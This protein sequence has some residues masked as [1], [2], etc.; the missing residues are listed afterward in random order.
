[1]P[2]REDKNKFLRSEEAAVPVKGVVPVD[3]MQGDDDEDTKLLR[4]MAQVARRYLRTF[5][6][7]KDV[8]NGYF[9]AGVGGVAAAFLFDATIVVEGVDA[10]EWV[11]V[12][13]GDIPSAYLSMDEYK[14]PY[15]ALERYTDG[16][17]EWVREAELGHTL[18]GL[19]PIDYP[20][21]REFI[22]MFRK[23][24]EFLRTFLLPNLA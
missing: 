4:E 21:T 7:C 20:P 16:L 3:D 18:S 24:V 6:W 11:W 12:F 10:T 22:E 2:L 19:I 14:T 8:R 15:L 17:A 23:R 9:G 5:A 1:M 13:V